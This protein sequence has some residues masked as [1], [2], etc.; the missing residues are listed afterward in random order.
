MLTRSARANW[1]AIAAE[2]YWMV[3]RRERAR[4]LNARAL[5]LDENLADAWIWKALYDV[6]QGRT[7]DARQALDRAQQCPGG[8]EA[9]VYLELL[10]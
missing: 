4:E 5:R 7:L 6:A 9:E 10:R 3:G 8:Q 2:A 1:F